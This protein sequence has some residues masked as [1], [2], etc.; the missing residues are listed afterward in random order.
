[1]LY[2]EGGDL[3]LKIV[4]DG[5]GFNFFSAV[6]RSLKGESM[7]ILGMQ[8]RV[9]LIGGKIKINSKPGGGTTVHTIFPGDVINVKFN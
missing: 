9:E 8:E 5:V 2:Y 7:G 3:H 4:D 1:M 6:Q